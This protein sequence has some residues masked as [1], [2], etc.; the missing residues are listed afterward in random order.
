[1]EKYPAFQLTEYKK[2]QYERRL[3]VCK[4]ERKGAT[5]NDVGKEGGDKQR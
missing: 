5:K 1:M 4:K 3:N 2:C